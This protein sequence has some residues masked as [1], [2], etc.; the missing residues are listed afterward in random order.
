MN[1]QRISALFISALGIISTFL[2]WEYIP[3][4]NLGLRTGLENKA[5]G[6]FTIVLFAIAF[7]ISLFGDKSKPLKG[8][9]FTVTII[10]SVLVVITGLFQVM[11]ILGNKENAYVGSP[12]SESISRQFTP[13][14]GL[15]LMI[16]CGV[17]L[18]VFTH[19]YKDRK[20][21]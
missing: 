19:L 4:F 12:L 17:S 21:K 5:Y 14:Y 9:A 3:W 1:K 18:F 11:S 16:L 10:S 15:F 6:K 2:P 7:L 8:K 20:V 13:E